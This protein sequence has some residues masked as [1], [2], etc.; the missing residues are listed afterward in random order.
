MRFIYFTYVILNIASCNN[1]ESICNDS[2]HNELILINN[3]NSRIYAEYYWNYPD[4]MIGEYN[5]VLSLS[6]GIQPGETANISRVTRGS[7]LEELY[8]NNRKEW[9]YIFDADTIETLDWNTV[10]TSQ[11]GLLTRLELSL[12]QMNNSN[13]TVIYE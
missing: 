5:P 7:C 13:F 6:G 4:T 11:R 8:A 2:S 12:S 9:V 10:R 1:E 3:S